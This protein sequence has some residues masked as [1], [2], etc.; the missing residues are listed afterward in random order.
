VVAAPLKRSWRVLRPGGRLVSIAVP[1]PPDR[2]LVDGVRA[3]WFVV[4]PNRDQL[5][6]IARLVDAGHVRPI[7]DSVP[8]L[9]RGREAYGSGS[10]G[11]GVG[12]SVL[13][14]ADDEA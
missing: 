1:R 7:V 2:S 8:P 12:K 4:E 10:A 3:V 13:E 6:D 5:V 9:A 14:I 11:H